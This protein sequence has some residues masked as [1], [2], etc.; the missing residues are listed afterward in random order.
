MKLFDPNVTPEEQELA[1]YVNREKV[2]ENIAERL[3]W[4]PN[5]KSKVVVYHGQGGIGKTIVRKM[6][7][8]RL[9]KSAKVPYVVIDYEPDGSPRSCEQTFRHMRRQLGTFGLK[10]PTFDL[11]WA[12]HWE[13]TTGQRISKVRFPPPELEDVTDIIS[14]IPILGNIPKAIAAFAKLSQ[15]AAQ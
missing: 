9:L 10:F 1:W 11:L 15:S 7:E 14:V 8:R 12:R 13:E 2:L 3:Q 4:Q 6:A 5:V